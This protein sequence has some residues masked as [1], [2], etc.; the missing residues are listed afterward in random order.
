MVDDQSSLVFEVTLIDRVTDLVRHARWWTQGRARKQRWLGL[1]HPAYCLRGA[2][3][4][5]CGQPASL[6]QSTGDLSQVWVALDEAARR[7]GHANVL[8]FNDDKRISHQ[9]V[10]SFLSEVRHHLLRERK[11]NHA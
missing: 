7:R 4:Q 6:V 11:T 10:L 5:A 3:H 9:D 2:L 8:H 1:A